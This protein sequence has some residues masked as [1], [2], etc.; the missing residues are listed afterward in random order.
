MH[1]KTEVTI[2]AP[3]QKVFTG[4]TDFGKMKEWIPGFEKAEYLGGAFMGPGTRLKLIFNEKGKE[5]TAIQEIRRVKWNKLIEYSVDEKRIKVITTVRFIPENDNSTTVVTE[6]E[7]DGKGFF[8]G[9][10]LPLMKPFI[11]SKA[12]KSQEMF[13]SVME[14]DHN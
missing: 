5:T 4:Y 13:K 2:N 12:N 3:L 14:E 7:I 11:S 1:Y 10:L 8:W 6:N 9:A